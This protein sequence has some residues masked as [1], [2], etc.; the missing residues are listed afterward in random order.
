[1]AKA[2]VVIISW[3]VQANDRG[4]DKNEAIFVYVLIEMLSSIY[5]SVKWVKM[6]I[7]KQKNPVNNRGWV[8]YF[9]QGGRMGY[10]VCDIL[11]T[12]TW[13]DPTPCVSSW[14]HFY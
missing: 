12:S 14:V 6:D 2:V 1:M 11:S 5:L 13:N 8:L 3:H 7:F 10:P 9:A 4:T